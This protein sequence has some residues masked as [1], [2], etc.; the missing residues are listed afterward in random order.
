MTIHRL[1]FSLLN[2]PISRLACVFVICFC[3]MAF[4][5]FPI[6][7]NQRPVVHITAPK[8]NDTFSWNKD[9]QYAIRVMDKEDGNS[10]YDEIQNHEVFLRITYRQD[11]SHLKSVIKS[12]AN[13]EEPKALTLLKRSTCFN[14]HASRSILIG[15]S[16]DRIASRYTYSEASVTALTEKVLHGS[17]GTWGEVPMP[18]NT[19]LQK[20]DVEVVVRWILKNNRSDDDFYQVGLNGTFRLNSNAIKDNLNGVVILTAS[21]WD[22]GIKENL[23][24]KKK[25]LHSLIIKQH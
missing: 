18:S 23:I 1:F 9:I 15:P 3:I 6:Q 17:K 16:F 5:N 11:T 22:H 19:D 7:E 13:E 2:N 10:A 24:M 8:E 20:E 4:N 21:Y 12:I 25:G 14:C